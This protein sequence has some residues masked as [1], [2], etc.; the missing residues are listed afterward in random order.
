MKR[1]ESPCIL[2]GMRW[3]RLR[4][5]RTDFSGIEAADVDG[6]DDATADS[7]AGHDHVSDMQT[8][9]TSGDI[10]ATI[11]PIRLMTFNTGTSEANGKADPDDRYTEWH[12][13]QSDE[14]YGDGLAWM[15]AIEAAKDF[16]DAKAPDIIAF[17]EIFH[18]AE[19]ADIPLESRTDFICT[20]WRPGD[21]TVASIITG[22]DYQVMC[23]PGKPDKCSAVRKS[24][25]RFRGCD[26]D[27]CLEGMTGC[28]VDT[29][30]KGARIGRHNRIEW[31]WRNQ[32]GQRPCVVWIQGRRDACWAWQ[33]E[34]IFVDMC[35]AGPGATGDV[36][37][38]M[39][40][41]NTDPGRAVI[42]DPSAARLLDF[43][44]V[45]RSSIS[46]GGWGRCCADVRWC[47]KHRSCRQQHP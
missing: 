32:P 41:F 19:C 1:P 11:P 36:S 7:H 31:R 14:Y 37:V 23:N 34:Q 13:S 26:D 25:G 29:C 20:D 16:I 15:P 44:G 17:Q 12:A 4:S 47:R 24:F 10:P 2:V 30:G 3:M 33:F 22:D 6:I 46:D 27:F 18:S 38:V 43:V 35:G 8:D 40:D 42:F 5:V 28:T 21:P 9:Q 39:G 45:T